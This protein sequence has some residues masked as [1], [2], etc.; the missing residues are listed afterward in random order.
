MSKQNDW[1]QLDYFRTFNV[2][3]F[4]SLSTR[5]RIKRR[6]KFTVGRWLNYLW[7][8]YINISRRSF[9]SIKRRTNSCVSASIPRGFDSL[10]RTILPWTDTK[11]I[12]SPGK[13]K[14]A[15]NYENQL[16]ERIQVRTLVQTESMNVEITKREQKKNSL[17]LHTVHVHFQL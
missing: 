7:I 1:K 10:I 4:H 6:V 11:R 12:K 16:L 14:Q 2:H 15:F 8:I 5:N 13:S 17:N 9:L 3:Q